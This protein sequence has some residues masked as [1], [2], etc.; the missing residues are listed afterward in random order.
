MENLHNMGLSCNM[1]GQMDAGFVTTGGGVDAFKSNNF[2]HY[3]KF[4][5]DNDESS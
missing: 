5:V 1:V 4:N 2:W 3:F